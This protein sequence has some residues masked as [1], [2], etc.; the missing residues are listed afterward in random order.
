MALADQGV[1]LRIVVQSDGEKAMGF[2]DDVDAGRRICPALAILDLNLP[3]IGG[4]EILERIRRSQGCG[5]V[6]VVVFSSSDSG[7][8][9][10][11]AESLGAS[12]YIK[13][14]SNLEDFLEVGK[15]LRELLDEAVV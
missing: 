3:R 1:T 9:K 5:K 8:D 10:Q 12:R 2:M 11:M 14:P 4:C 13:K 7:R 15:M 6:P